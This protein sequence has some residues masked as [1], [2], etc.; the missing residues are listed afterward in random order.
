MKKLLLATLLIS[1]IL[2]ASDF[3]NDDETFT[4]RTSI[5]NPIS[6]SAIDINFG[7]LQRGASSTETTE[8]RVDGNSG[9]KYSLVLTPSSQSTPI[10]TGDTI[11]GNGTSIFFDEVPTVGDVNS[12]EDIIITLSIDPNYS[13]GEIIYEKFDTVVIP[14]L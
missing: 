11:S 3:S 7:G 9:S 12:T 5:G 10:S 13:G 14:N 2:S 4:V 6:V 8:L 1:N